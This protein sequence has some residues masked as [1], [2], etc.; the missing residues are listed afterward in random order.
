MTLSRV[1]V[2]VANA[3]LFAGCL[4]TA[5]PAVGAPSLDHL[6]HRLFPELGHLLSPDDAPRPRFVDPRRD[7]ASAGSV[8][9]DFTAIPPTSSAS[10]VALSARQRR[11]LDHRLATTLPRYHHLFAG[12]A[13]RY[14][15]PTAF[16]AAIAYTESKWRP[17]ARH[18]GVAGMMMLS[19]SAARAVGVNNRLSAAE[20]VRGGARYL[21]RLRGLIS[22]AVPRPDRNY[23]ALAAYNMGIGH[24]RDAETLARHLGKN[25]YLWADLKQVIPLLAER[26]YYRGLEHGYARGGDV[27]TY[28]ERVR[29]CQTLIA[30][31]LE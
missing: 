10:I 3:V 4:S 18:R 9:I 21:A 26:R 28:I 14:G 29:G 2:R 6:G 24:L 20:S 19:S 30:P 5:G 7:P 8:L 15:L 16:L 27:V 23:F 13:R 11:A 25:P 22:N 12:A 17:H 1:V 31:H